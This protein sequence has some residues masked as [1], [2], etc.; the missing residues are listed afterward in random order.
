[1]KDGTHEISHPK[2]NTGQKCAKYT[3]IRTVPLEFLK[4]C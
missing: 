3:L 1:M 4:S 2:Q